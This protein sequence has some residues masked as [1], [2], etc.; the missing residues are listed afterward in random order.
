MPYCD[1]QSQAGTPLLLY[2]NIGR[3]IAENMRHANRD[4]LKLTTA[5]VL[6]LDGR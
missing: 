3:K 4:I 2:Y 6:V 5:F 1:E